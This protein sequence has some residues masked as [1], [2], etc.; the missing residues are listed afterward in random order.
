MTVG[1]K[2]LTVL[3]LAM[4]GLS[5]GK[6]SGG[7]DRQGNSGSGGDDAG[8]GRRGHAAGQQSSA[9]IQDQG[10]PSGVSVFS[11]PSDQQV[12]MSSP[13]AG[14]V[15]GP[16]WRT[17][18]SNPSGSQDASSAPDFTSR[19]GRLGPSGPGPDMDAARLPSTSK[20]GSKVSDDP[21]PL[22]PDSS[23]NVSSSDEKP[24]GLF[25][26]I[27]EGLGSK[28]ETKTRGKANLAGETAGSTAVPPADEAPAGPPGLVS[29]Q[30]SST[31][32]ATQDVGISRLAP[33]YD[34]P[35]ASP[36][37][38]LTEFKASSTRIQ[39]ALANK[40]TDSVDSE[41]AAVRERAA[42]LR[43]RMRNLPLDQKLQ[44]GSISHMYDDGAAM[45]E[46]GRK[47]GQTPKVEMGLQKIEE[48]NRSLEKLE[49]R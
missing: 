42:C 3:A 32:R 47:T 43:G 12:R 33:G 37:E 31:V 45:L 4:V 24:K 19:K 20:R 17:V 9:K 14:P 18:P 7:P 49:V 23:S 25:S 44:L 27:R 41:I 16:G 48:A 13:D 5:F 36:S 29:P 26:R 35:T 15:R 39:Q 46:E 10:P 34:K 2:I 6:P 22:L 1:T 8:K 38:V 21:G 28:Q 40:Q 30:Q 11:G